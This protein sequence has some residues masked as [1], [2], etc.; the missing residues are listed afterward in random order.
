MISLC[1]KS[2][3]LL[4]YFGI[5][6]LPVANAPITA[7][8]L[9]IK[10]HLFRLL[11][12]ASLVLSLVM[13]FQRP[14]RFPA[15]PTGL[16]ASIGAVAILLSLLFSE[17]RTA[18]VPAALDAVSCLA[19]LLLTRLS[20]IG[21]S[22]HVQGGPLMCAVGLSA[23]VPAVLF[24]AETHR[25]G[26][27]DTLGNQNVVSHFLVLAMAG[28]LYFLG[29][30]SPLAGEAGRGVSRF[31]FRFG[32]PLIF[33]ASLIWVILQTDARGAVVGML[34]ASALIAGL[35][36]IRHWKT[37]PRALKILCL[38]VSISLAL[39]AP[40]LLYGYRA[41]SDFNVSVR[42]LSWKYSISLLSD[43]LWFGYGPGLFV[44]SFEKAKL[45]IS[46][47]DADLLGLLTV[48]YAHNDY[49]ELAV[50]QGSF[51]LAAFLFLVIA[52]GF[53][54]MKLAAYGPPGT[55]AV[56][57]AVLF[58]VTASLAQAFFDFPY[59]TPAPRFLLHVLLG[60]LWSLD[61]PP[62][63]GEEKQS[64]PNKSGWES[65]EWAKA[66]L[67]VMTASVPAIPVIAAYAASVISKVADPQF[68]AG[69]YAAV[70]HLQAWSAELNPSNALYV[71]RR[72][73]GEEQARESDAA[74]RSFH[75][76]LSMQPYFPNIY[77]HL[78]TLDQA[79]NPTLAAAHFSASAA[80]QPHPAT[81]HNLAAV[82]L[83]IGDTPAA[84]GLYNEI[85]RRYPDDDRARNNAQALKY[86]LEEE[87]PAV[88]RTALNLYFSGRYDQAERL[89]TE[90]LKER[91]ADPD[92]IFL[93][94]RIYFH[95]E[96][97]EPAEP[98]FR[99]YAGLR[100]DDAE[101]QYYLG[102]LYFY[103]NR[104]DL[105]IRAY[106]RAA[107]LSPASPKMVYNLGVNYFTLGDFASMNDCF[108]TVLT[109]NPEVSMK[110]KMDELRQRALRSSRP[111]PPGS[112]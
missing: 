92:G 23:I 20:F 55:T 66:A 19:V 31:L 100:P 62:N 60:I 109:I 64:P 68:K 99:Q 76:A 12:V 43:R 25:I 67:V 9:E 35:L 71:F 50:E 79:A 16:A 6:I 110:S 82:A 111:A 89:A 96:K 26:I 21:L 41:S 38:I 54:P 106:R 56:S 91:P 80:F 24:I 13:V 57:V 70:R 98:L 75:T 78:G 73:L 81:L 105:S 104:P 46:D 74:R 37:F 32:I 45:W 51:G 36:T 10:T 61:A 18:S 97:Y 65:F 39:A 33:T 1:E 69:Q 107:D 52:A 17:N 48:N 14:D 30:S 4:I 103:Q 42:L 27:S 93:L 53:R 34:A 15:D 44:S 86:M 87:R 101:G 29:A 90:F 5:L 2:G 8:T 49:V 83:A 63:T 102:N 72:A 88:Y 40:V 108:D 28:P 11:G 77:F 3:R 22:A 94:A 7:D 85:A 95:R 58:G 47:A 59:H 84:A 112:P